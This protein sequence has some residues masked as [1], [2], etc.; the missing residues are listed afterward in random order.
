MLSLCYKRYVSSFS[1]LTRPK[2]SQ[3]M[4]RNIK[5]GILTR[6]QFFFEEYF[7]VY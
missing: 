3:N 2:V 5:I 7:V 1:W 4:N 6:K